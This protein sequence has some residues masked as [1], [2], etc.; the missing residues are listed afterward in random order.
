MTMR[1]LADAIGVHVSYIS[2]LETGSRTRMSPPK[3]AALR[4]T[5]HETD[6]QLLDPD[7]YPPKEAA[8]DHDHL[9]AGARRDAR[10]DVCA[11]CSR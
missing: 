4:T 3:Y 5:L 10:V 9:D 11:G 6:E 7:E 1:E 8:R 2:R